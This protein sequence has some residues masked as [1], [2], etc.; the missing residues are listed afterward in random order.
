MSTSRPKSPSQSPVIVIGAGIGGLVA[1]LEL[2]HRGLPVTVLD[3]GPAPG[4]KIR[5]IATPAGPVDGGPTV[6]T[7]AWVFEALFDAVGE[8]LDA[9]VRRT[10]LDVLARH[11]WRGSPRLDLF[12]DP[13]QSRDAVGQF[14]GAGEARAFD[15][16][17]ARAARL[18][19]AF[20][21]PVMR[22]ADPSPLGVAAA[23]WKRGARLLAD[24]APGR[25]YAG[26]L[27]GTFRDPR[28]RQLFGRYATYVG[29]SPY[30]SPAILALIWQAE[31][32]GVDRLEGGMTALAG[33]IADLARRRGVR[34]HPNTQATR[35]IVENGAVAAVE[36]ADT[37]LPAATVVFNGDPAALGAG[38]LGADAV[39]VHP[40]RRPRQRSLSA[41]VWTFASAARDAPL[42][43][44]NVFFSD[45]YGAEFNDLFRDRRLPTDPTLY[46]CAQDRGGGAVPGSERFQIIM[47]APADG[48]GHPPTDQEIRLCQ[49]RV[50]QRLG[51]AALPLS[52]PQTEAALTTP[53]DFARMFPGS[54]GALYGP[55]PHAIWTTFRRPPARTALPGLYLA[56]GAVHP[57][58]GVPMAALSGRHA[59]AAI[60]ADRASTSP[61][62]RTAMPGGMSTASRTAAGAVSR[63]SPS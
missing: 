56:G 33:A 13:A 58:P 59:A 57:G 15:R 34:F 3:R 24:M 21:A 12:A 37:R 10:R 50:F 53:W 1:A 25:S 9:H 22:A 36:T 7:M 43:H 39:A 18:F 16:F 26:A 48:D 42:A 32:A 28:L 63:S 23:T 40:P 46:V 41:W 38:L 5:A 55:H 60:I 29:G 30:L 51:E 2:A 19:Q 20:D 49:T 27:A 17:C 52:A 4:G 47:N 44:H 14:A 8:T 62:R 35:I 11:H 6:F 61:S 45:A 31:A 54:G